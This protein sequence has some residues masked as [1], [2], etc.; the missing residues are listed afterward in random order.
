M[1]WF[2]YVIRLD[3]AV[4]RDELMAGLAEDGIPSRPYFAPIHLQPFYRGRLG[5]RPGDFPVAERVALS[6]LALP[7]FADMTEGQVDLVC[8]RLA[9]RVGRACRLGAVAVAV[10]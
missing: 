2:V 9:D 4:D 10:G 5:H 8:E 6:T 7:F 1:S 3:E